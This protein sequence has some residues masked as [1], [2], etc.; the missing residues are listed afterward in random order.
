M[1]KILITFSG[2]PYEATTSLIVDRATSMGADEVFVY[3][4]KWLTE[5]PFYEQNKWLWE[6]PHKRGF[7]WYVWKP[8]IIWD[9]LQKAQNGD[10]VMFIDADAV[11]IDDFGMLFDICAK[12]GGIMLFAAETHKHYKW[13]KKDC[14]MVMG[15]DEEK[16]RDVQAGVAR[17]MLFQKGSWKATQ[18]LMEW[19]T[20][21][22]NPKANTFD[23]STIAP[24]N[25]GFIEHRAEQAIMTNLGHKYGLKFY[26][27]A[28]DAGYPFSHDKELY[29][30][31]F[32]QINNNKEKVTA[33]PIGSIY[34]NV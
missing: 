3:D 10:V 32:Q 1:K 29:P 27:E 16:Y 14:Y 2:K 11:P 23:D 30:Q 25:E 13:C 24:E 9:A 31:L 5:Q 20:Y 6:H 8:Y 18:F 7:G 34:R 15:Q 4:D 21:C 22:V 17:F 19:I 12:D 33:D 28:C 26:R